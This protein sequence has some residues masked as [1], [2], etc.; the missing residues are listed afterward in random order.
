MGPAQRVVPERVRRSW[1]DRVLLADRL[2]M[3]LLGAGLVGA[4]VL[5]GVL[6]ISFTDL[7]EILTVRYNSA[8]LPVEIREKAALFRLPV[9]GLLAWILNGGFGL[10]LLTRQQAIGAYM[11]WGG[12]IVVQIFS[13]VALVSLIT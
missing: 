11:L 4:L 8:G 7:P 10:W 3:L 12:A 6:M 13:L 2:G 5:F 9:I 1:L